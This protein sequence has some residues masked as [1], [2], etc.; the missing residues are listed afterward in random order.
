MGKQKV[1]LERAVTSIA[2]PKPESKK[3]QEVM[4]CSMEWFVLIAELSASL[5]VPLSINRLNSS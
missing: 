5:M 4:P 3:E 1:S 2:K